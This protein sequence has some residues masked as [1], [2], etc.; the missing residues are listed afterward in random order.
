MKFSKKKW[1]YGVS[2]R[3]KNPYF[4]PIVPWISTELREQLATVMTRGILRRSQ[5][6]TQQVEEYD[7]QI[8]RYTGMDELTIVQQRALRRLVTERDALIEELDHRAGTLKDKMQAEAANFCLLRG[9][10]EI[11]VE[12]YH[13]Y[14]DKNAGE[15]I[16]FVTAPIKIGG[17]VL[18]TYD[19]YLDP[20]WD[21]PRRAFDLVR[22]DY[23]R[24]RGVHPHF[25]SGGPCYGSFGPTLQGMLRIG[26]FVS[27]MGA[28][29]NYLATYNGGSPLAR[30][31]NFRKGKMYE[32]LQ[33]LA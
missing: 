5:S 33:P 21:I 23:S 15:S 12:P 13:E 18:G 8:R 9:V 17:T 11:Y 3:T 1:I 22:R 2:G 28:Y 14:L 32:N 19:I 31:N 30:L 25:T 27:V 26:S 6:D 24:V 7:S 10:R 4:P 20:R 16:V 29:L